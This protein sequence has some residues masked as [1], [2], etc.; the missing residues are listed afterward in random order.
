LGSST[1]LR[2]AHSQP[3]GALQLVARSTDGASSTWAGAGAAEFTD[4][5]IEGLEDRLRNRLAW[6]ATRLDRPAGRYE[7][8]L[9]AE[10]VSDLMCNLAFEAGGRDAEDG[11]T[12]FS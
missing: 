10:A 3:E 8:I 1:G 7:V 5:S 11:K 4:V 6:S 9:P 2:L 12:G